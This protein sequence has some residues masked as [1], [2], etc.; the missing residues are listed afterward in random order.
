VIEVTNSCTG[1]ELTIG[2]TGSILTRGGIVEVN[3]GPTNASG[4]SGSISLQFGEGFLVVG[5]LDGGDANQT[6]FEV[7]ADNF[8]ATLTAQRNPAY[9]LVR[10]HENDGKTR[11]RRATEWW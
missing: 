8:T 2:G 4:T 6:H 11:G 1:R 9:D 5:G 10:F 7:T 3:V